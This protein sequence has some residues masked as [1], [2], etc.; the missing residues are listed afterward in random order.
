[1][2][3]I[4][5]LSRYIPNWWSCTQYSDSCW[6]QVLCLISYIACASTLQ[7]EN[8]KMGKNDSPKY[9]IDSWL[10]WDRIDL[11]TSKIIMLP[12]EY[13][14]EFSISKNQGSNSSTDNSSHPK[15]YFS[16]PKKASLERKVKHGRKRQPARSS[17]NQDLREVNSTND[18]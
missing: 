14:K 18:F 5:R 8:Y 13:H 15:R 6:D 11:K 4:V 17:S 7:I 9:N 16:K 12:K 1:M 3:K 10:P 2:V